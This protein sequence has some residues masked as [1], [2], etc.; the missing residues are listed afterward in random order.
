MV[1]LWCYYDDSDRAAA[2]AQ[3][4]DRERDM[5]NFKAITIHPEKRRKYETS[6]YASYMP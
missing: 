4:N 5:R 3:K 1:L 2:A 6:L